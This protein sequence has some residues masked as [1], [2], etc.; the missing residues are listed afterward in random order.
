[1][2]ELFSIAYNNLKEKTNDLSKYTK[3]ELVELLHEAKD[4]QTQYNNLQLVVKANANSLYGVSA[5][6]YF[7]LC[8]IDVAEDITMTG[9]HF[10]VIVDRAINKFFVNWGEKELEIIRKFYPKV[11]SLRKFT[12]Y[13]PD[14]RNDLCVY[15]DTDS[16]YINLHGIYELL[17]CE[18][19][20]GAKVLFPP[21][22][23]EGNK[24]LSDFAI[25]M[26]ESF[27]NK[28]IK[29]TIDDE[30][31]YRNAIKGR[32]IMNHEVTTRRSILQKKKKYILSPIWENGKLLKKTKLKFKGVELK[33]GS[34]SPRS[35]KILSKLIEKYILENYSIEDLRIEVI[36]I[37]KYVKYRKEKDFLYLVSSVS[38]LKNIEKNSKG[39]YVSDKNHIQM[40]IA[41][42]WMNFITEHKLNEEYQPPFEYQKMNYYYCSS[43]SNYTVIGIPDDVDINQVPNLPEPDWNRMIN[44]TLVKPLL[45]YIL[46]KDLIDDK[47]MEQFIL[48]IQSWNF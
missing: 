47:D 20:N 40:Q 9:K 44:A 43:E 45:R 12:E 38:G 31:E 25:F 2:S 17:I 30:C 41:L 34:S 32:L 23:Y 10:G 11:K 37:I 5:S 16:R 28:I 3:E 26:M 46:E 29:D 15:G 14:T 33:R 13:V 7:S 27:I 42:S 35:K 1:M 24:E 4:V 18:E 22:T 21:S 36:K 48:G 39:I 8:D 19:G 6:I